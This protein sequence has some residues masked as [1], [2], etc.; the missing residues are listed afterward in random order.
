MTATERLN[1][2]LIE[3]NPQVREALKTLLRDHALKIYSDVPPFLSDAT[4][5]EPDLIL[6]DLWVER[7]GKEV[8]LTGDI[9]A[10][11]RQHPQAELVVQSAVQEV[12]SMRECI[13]QGAAKFLMKEHLTEEIPPLLAWTLEVKRLRGE[14]EVRLLG[15]SPVMRALKRELLKLRFQRGADVLIEGET[16]SGKEVCAQFLHAE[17]PFIAVNVAA[18]ASDLF[19]AEF[20]G[21]EKGAYTGSQ[22]ARPGFLEAAG[23]GTLFLDEVQSMPLAQQAKLLR[24]LETRR[25]T[26]VGATTERPFRARIVSAA[27]TNLRELVG[28]GQFREDLYFRLSALHVK[29]P[30]LRLR[31]ADIPALARWFVQ[32]PGGG[33]KKR[34]TIEAERFL[35]ES[36]DWP[37]N[38]RE[39]RALVR[40]L[41]TKSPL[42]VFDAPE[43]QSAL[44]ELSGESAA[45]TTFAGPGVTAPGNAPSPGGLPVH[46]PMNWEASFDDNIERL[47]KFMLE[48]SLKRNKGAAV[49]DKLKL[50]R[51]R[52]Y[53]KMRQHG[54]HRKEFGESI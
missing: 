14:L 50:A 5:P 54:L 51:S 41:L 12:A 2:V 13:R 16:G 20:F 32:A 1:V 10:V 43:V 30:A 17:G 26:R 39:L 11:Q 45:R 47:E 9:P 18:V 19:E 40:N 34:F 22:Q 33:A 21:A 8:N 48:E 46:F 29:V 3:D 28:K 44:A 31:G 25:F 53:E 35:A 4:A 42:P 52:F 6:M 49:R 7:D 27:N 15:S 24:V 37:G 23:T 36:Y 38:V